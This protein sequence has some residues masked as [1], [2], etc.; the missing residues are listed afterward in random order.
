MKQGS[1]VR[2]PGDARDRAHVHP[3]LQH[4]RE[5]RVAQRLK[6]H[7]FQ[8]GAAKQPGVTALLKVDPVDVAAWLV[9]KDKRVVRPGRA[10][11][12]PLRSRRP[13]A[14]AARSPRARQRHATVRARSCWF[15]HREATAPWRV[16]GPTDVEPRLP[17]QHRTVETHVLPQ[18]SQELA[19]PHPRPDGYHGEGFELVP[20]GCGQQCPCL[21]AIQVSGSLRTT[22][23]ADAMAC[24]TCAP[25]PGG[26]PATLPL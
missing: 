26:E 25:T 17:R 10:G 12:K 13:D 2:V 11:G 22:R 8:L 3:V 19:L 24:G 15:Y 9:D 4:E 20:G 1:T 5:R 18:Q 6:G 21:I 23:A 16:H 14:G 7:Q